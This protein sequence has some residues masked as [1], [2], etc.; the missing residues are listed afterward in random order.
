MKKILV[1]TALFFAATA[2]NAQQLYF[3]PASIPLEDI[4]SNL[5]QNAWAGGINFPLW[6]SI[7][8]N[9]DG[10][11][12]L[13]MYDKTNDRVST[14]LND[15]STGTHAYHY[16]PEYL[17]HFPRV[18]ADAWGICYDYNCDG[19]A[20]FFELDSAHS[21][22]EVWRN[23]YS[24]Q[25][26][27][28]FTRVSAELMEDWS[29]PAPINV[30]ATTIYVP[31]FIDVDNDG[32]M[33]IIC[34]NNP[35]N[36]KFAYHKNL[37]MDLYG[38]CDSLEFVFDDKCWGNFTLGLGSNSVSSYH[39]APCGTPSPA[40]SYPG[41]GIE[42]AKRDDTITTVCAIDIDGDGAKEL[43]IGDQ[44]SPNSLMVHNGGTPQAAEMDNS[45]PTFPTY[46]ISVNIFD[47]VHHAYIDVDNDG[48][49]DLLA[50]SG[51]LEDKQGVWYYKNTNTDA[52]PIFAL[53]KTD[54]IQNEMLETGQGACPVF[55]DADADG[56]MDI[57]VAH[58]VY[59][60]SVPGIVSRL[61]LYKNI[62]TGTAPAFRHVTDDYATLSNY[63]LFF[64]I[65]AT[66]GDL[67]GD[68][69]QDMIIGDFA[70][71]I[72]Y[73]NNSAG[74][75]NPANL[76]LT[77]PV[78]MGI[79]VGN[80]ATP[81]LVDLDN[82][83]LLDLVIGKQTATFNYYHNNGTAN[84]PAFPSVATIDTLGHILLAL[85]GNFSGYSVPY[86][87]TH[88]AHHQMLTANMHG[89]IYY[90]DNIDNN[91]NG[92]FTRLDTVASG[93]F[94]VRSNG[95]NIHVSGGDINHDG[96]MDMLVGLYGGGIQI[97]YGSNTPISV[98]EVETE[99]TFSCYPNPTSSQLT[100]AGRQMVIKTVEIYNVIGEIVWRKNQ[101]VRVKNQ[102]IKVD[103]S[104]FSPG[105]YIVVVSDEK[106]SQRGRVI[107][108]R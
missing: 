35:A 88:N 102:E 34:F 36:G 89:D 30:Y 100:I 40:G 33:D 46:D 93:E 19:K 50:S 83:G 51:Q 54:F 8:L 66:F 106:T 105:M 16:A 68:N 98:A 15:G 44:A 17:K 1:Y 28:Q 71:N 67:D 4:N 87:F 12:D 104:K 22:I 47:Y 61:S 29:G 38:V 32:D 31:T 43:L 48:K 37:S 99:G 18:L 42:T 82:D 56:L 60:T 90:Y 65:V 14:F 10:L 91:L 94:G 6:S 49:R 24:I 2:T 11:Q 7:D 45:D 41:G 63:N 108:Q 75:G 53:Q 74:A 3:S 69:D 77:A 27:L 101:D 92:T 81:Q 13:Y 39:N 85:I 97:Y 73:F 78:Y 107:V 84:N 55:F 103:V 58:G 9:G 25:N 76:A 20:D 96:M 52:A 86:I 21:G 5:L 70:G 95:F 62:G 80:N 64:P 26:G 79:D 23:D 72:H 59:D 57:V